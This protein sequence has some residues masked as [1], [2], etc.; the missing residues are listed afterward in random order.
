MIVGP[1]KMIRF[2]CIR[3]PFSISRPKFH[4]MDEKYVGCAYWGATDSPKSME[5]D[6]KI[7]LFSLKNL[8]QNSFAIY[9]NAEKYDERT[10]FHFN[11]TVIDL[12][13]ISWF[14]QTTSNMKIRTV[15]TLTS[16][17]A[18]IKDR[19][20]HFIEFAWRCL[21]GKSFVYISWVDFAPEQSL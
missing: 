2:L 11:C 18:N 8:N 21:F 1:L 3:W 14:R 15:H 20:F 5:I 4:V 9:E 10:S 7:G 12:F 6:R 17:I 19:N 13:S 16:S